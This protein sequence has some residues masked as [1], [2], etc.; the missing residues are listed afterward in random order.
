MGCFYI[1]LVSTARSKEC[2]WPRWQ[3]DSIHYMNPLII[4][5]IKITLCWSHS[6]S[7]YSCHSWYQY[8]LHEEYQP[9]LCC[10][11]FP[12]TFSHIFSSEIVCA[13][14]QQDLPPLHGFYHIAHQ[15]HLLYRKYL[16]AVF[17]H[18]LQYNQPLYIS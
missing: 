8:K 11:P 13:S 4:Y 7:F 1:V 18:I 6:N 10:H 16:S 5:Y 3:K 14:L 9:V 2:F 12:S 17:Q 15:V